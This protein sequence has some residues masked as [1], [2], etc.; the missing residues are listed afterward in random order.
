MHFNHCAVELFLSSFHSFESWNCSSNLQLQI[1][2]ICSQ[3]VFSR[4][5]LANQIT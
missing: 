5:V 2:V 4:T 1:N 3:A